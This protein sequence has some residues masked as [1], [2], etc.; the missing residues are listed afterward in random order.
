MSKIQTQNPGSSEIQSPLIAGIT[1]GLNKLSGVLELKVGMLSDVKLTAVS[2]DSSSDNKN[3]IYEAGLGN[4]LWL[5]S[6][7]P[8]FKKNGTVITQE[9]DNFSIDYVGGSITFSVLNKPSDSDEIT[10]SCSYIVGESETISQIT[11]TLTATTNQANKY[12]GNYNDLSSLKLAHST[13]KNGD[14]AIVFSPLAVYAWKNDGWYDTR[15]I[16]DLSD[17]YT[18]S[19]ANN[20]LNQKE[21]KIKAKGSSTSYDN[22]YWGG[23]KTWQDLFAKVRSV[24]LTGLSTASS[25]VVT[26]SD[27][28]LVA[29][30]KLQAQ[31]SKA[32]Q[33]AYLSGTGA[34][35]S[36]T[37]GAVGQRY[38]NTSNGDEY[39]CV[40]A[41]GGTYTWKMHTR[42]IN[43]KTPQSAGGNVQ[44]TYTDV[45]AL[46]KNGTA[47]SAKTASAC[48]GNSATATKLRT[49]RNIGNASFDGTKN[50]SLSDMGAIE[51][52]A[53]QY[54]TSESNTGKTWID[55]KPIYRRVFKITGQQLPQL[56]YKTYVPMS[57]FTNIAQFLNITAFLYLE[58][59][60]TTSSTPIILPCAL[61]DSVVMI[62]SSSRGVELYRTK[63]NDKVYEGTAAYPK[64]ST[65]SITFIVEYTK[66]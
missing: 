47:V 32:T 27:T 43:G 20:L 58:D 66:K 51:K 17:Y 26:A 49:A 39:T 1:D 37:A 33:R 38:V 31:V 21:P 12:K 63:L 5:S 48:T 25:A 23:R 55:G 30:G 4:K 53:F 29:I 28:I 56:Q 62:Q 13:A 34:P 10:V 18:K 15:S 54:S 41:S 45:G 3:R 59:P 11:N 52:S 61:G 65:N 44:I 57:S 19:E 42:S 6:P 2:I 7:A 35:T 9:K 14:F 50:I 8:V 40:S 46:G 36:S 60:N 16:E 64:G 22:Y 24:T